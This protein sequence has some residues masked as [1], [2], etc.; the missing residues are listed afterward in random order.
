[1]IRLEAPGLKHQFPA[2]WRAK[3]ES[4]YTKHAARAREDFPLKVRFVTYTLKYPICTW[5]TLIGLEEHYKQARVEAERHEKGF[6]VKTANVRSLRLDLWPG[7]VRD[8]I[9]IDI[10][11]QKMDKVLPYQAPTAEL[12]VYL[13]KQG[14]RWVSV[15]PERMRIDRLRAPQKAKDLQ[16]PIDDAFMSPFLCVR[17]TKEPWHEATGDYARANLERFAKEWSKYLRGRLPLKNDVDVTAA[18]LASFNLILFG[19]PASNSLIEQVLP[20][21]PLK[22]T[23]KQISWAGKDYDASKH[24]PVLIYPSPLATDRYVVLNSGHTFRG[25]DFRGTNALLYPRLGDHAILRL[26]PSK[27]DALNVEVVAAGLFDEFWRLPARR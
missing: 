10:D 16:G 18:E 25:A 20:R 5:V 19:D 7:A 17:G 9:E 26:A 23:K 12:S 24:V 1:M 6:K 2:E 21:L 14:G 15:L 27:E 11:G 22:W 4:L 13:E 3:A 8:A